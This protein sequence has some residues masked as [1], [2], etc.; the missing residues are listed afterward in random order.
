[1]FLTEPMSL[2]AIRISSA[3]KIIYSYSSRVLTY[4]L[5]A[6]CVIGTGFERWSQRSILEASH[7]I[8]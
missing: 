4:L 6:H 8:S 1:M 3:H 7:G 5:G 2:L